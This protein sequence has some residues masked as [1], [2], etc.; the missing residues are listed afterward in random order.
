MSLCCQVCRAPLASGPQTKV[1]R[2]QKYC[3]TSCRQAAYRLRKNQKRSLWKDQKHETPGA[4][5]PTPA[6]DPASGRPLPT[7]ADDILGEIA[8]DVVEGARQL[9]RSVSD[10]EAE[11]ALRGALQVRACLDSLLAGLVAR[12][13]YGGLTWGRISGLLDISEDTARHRYTETTI[14]RRLRHHIRLDAR[15]TLDSLFGA[16]ELP[17]DPAQPPLPRH[18]NT[19]A[20]YNRLAPVLSMLARSSKMSLQQLSRTAGCSPSYLSRIL[21]GERV[22]AWPLT[23]RFA[24]AC[25]ADP[26]VLRK[27]WETEQLRDKSTATPTDTSLALLP[28][29]THEVTSTDLLMKAL[30]TQHV[31]AGQPTDLAIAVASQWRLH[32]EKV[33]NLLE[34]TSL[35][36]WDDLQTL[37]H[38]L[39]GSI[40]YFKALW[41]AA[42]PNTPQPA[43]P[44]IPPASAT[45]VAPD[46]EAYDTA[47]P[48]RLRPLPPED[49]PPPAWGRI[50]AVPADPTTLGW[51]LTEEQP[52]LA[53]EELLL[54]LHDAKEQLQHICNLM[55]PSADQL[56]GSLPRLQ[57]AHVHVSQLAS[58][59]KERTL[60]AKEGIK[61]LNGAGNCLFQIRTAVN[62]QRVFRKREEVDA[63][64]SLYEPCIDNLRDARALAAQLLPSEQQSGTTRNRQPNSPHNRL[65]RLGTHA[66]STR[67]PHA[68][69]EWPEL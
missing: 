1:G 4:P 26:E 31:R 6:E 33:R 24:L 41:E 3:G 46:T 34:G 64:R 23:E 50:P 5:R 68:L 14:L 58:R 63:F 55:E 15:Q 53:E 37:L 32:P 29:D 19:G 42:A 27:L 52:V 38:V 45:A 51:H 2:P 59:A 18:H 57:Q 11:A 7:T 65:H 16:G 54:V 56:P 35:P 28:S 67:Q 47:V 60:Y 44:A 20:A 13:R 39:G 61:L 69:R 12:A 62:R 66:H 10:R 48:R 30:H 17:E 43:A 49:S 36:D 8:K 9:L 22:P 25:Q 40:K 21:S